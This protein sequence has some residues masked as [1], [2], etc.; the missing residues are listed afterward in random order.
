MVGE[1]LWSRF[2]DHLFHDQ[3]CYILF[4]VSREN[5]LTKSIISDGINGC[6][7]V[8]NNLIRNWVATFHEKMYSPQTE[9]YR[10]AFAESVRAI[11]DTKIL[12]GK[13]PSKNHRGFLIKHHSISLS[14]PNKILREC[15]EKVLIRFYQ[16]RLYGRK[17]KE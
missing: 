2:P 16:Q 3:D 12:V 1:K 5:Y 9:K 14:F 13:S 10:Q 11:I 15:I 6:G 17:W 7:P 8:P 4:C